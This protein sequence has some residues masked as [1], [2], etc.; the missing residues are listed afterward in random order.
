MQ[1]QIQDTVDFTA[2][3]NRTT[4]RQIISIKQF[5][6]LHPYQG[7][8]KK[9]ERETKSAIKIKLELCTCLVDCIGFVTTCTALRPYWDEL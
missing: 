8:K 7:F 1:T 9:R 3:R 2:C 6:E 4:Y 5:E